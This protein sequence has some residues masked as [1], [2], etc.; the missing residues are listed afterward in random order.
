M[1]LFLKFAHGNEKAFCA[2]SGTAGHPH[3]LTLLP[4]CLNVVLALVHSDAVQRP[5]LSFS[6]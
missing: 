2:D 5:Q 4:L 3:N 6:R 1:I